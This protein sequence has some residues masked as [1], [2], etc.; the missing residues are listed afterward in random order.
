MSSG[1]PTDEPEDED[2]D[3]VT[4]TWEA[5]DSEKRRFWKLDATYTVQDDADEFIP[6]PDLVRINDTY[7]QLKKTDID[8]NRLRDTRTKE[9]LGAVYISNTCFNKL[10]KVQG[11]GTF[12]HSSGVPIRLREGS[13]AFAETVKTAPRS[14][15]TRNPTETLA[16]E[17][18][19]NNGVKAD[20]QYISLRF[21]NPNIDIMLRSL[22]GM[23]TADE[24]KT[25]VDA[26][27][28]VTKQRV[29]ISSDLP[30]ALIGKGF[31][32]V[33]CP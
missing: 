8:D 30:A 29:T 26:N 20:S 32:M 11:A 12:D 25:I 31:I 13:P 19:F 5:V 1:G 2:G 4:F 7:V 16:W 22:G 23:V 21:A 9:P 6:F 18:F 27:K 17:K 24:F 28:D 33:C 15:G 3:D 10:K 14:Q